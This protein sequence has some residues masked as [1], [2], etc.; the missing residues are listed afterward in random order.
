MVNKFKWYIENDQFFFLL[1]LGIVAIAAFGLG[2]VSVTGLPI[3]SS[4]DSPEPRIR[5]IENNAAVDD[6]LTI[7]PDAATS[8]TVVGS[9]N[10]SRYYD[11][12]CSGVDRIALE[13]RLYFPTSKQAL[14]AG[15]TP[16]VRCYE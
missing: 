14:A 11:L 9:R 4:D 7:P 8:E 2:R 3:I 6:R 15:Y 12:T 10:G 1:V 16:S 5:L 13:N